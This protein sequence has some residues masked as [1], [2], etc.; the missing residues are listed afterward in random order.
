MINNKEL[1]SMYSLKNIIRYNNKYTI[2]KESVAEHSFYVAIIAM[3]ICEKLKL[4]K[5]IQYEVLIKALLHDMPEII[6]NDITHDTKKLLNLQSLLNIYEK[7]YYEENF[8]E[9]IHILYNFNNK[10]IIDSIVT[11]ADILSVKQFCILEKK[12]GNSTNDLKIIYKDTLKRENNIIKEL[13]GELN[14][15]IK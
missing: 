7:K 4:P 8:P 14:N 12:L 9:Y 13:K 2:T 10:K 15:E 6:L 3:K 5:E 1:L 11:L